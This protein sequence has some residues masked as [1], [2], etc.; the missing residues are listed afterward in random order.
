M[1]ASHTVTQT[2]NYLKQFLSRI[3]FKNM[4]RVFFKC[5]SL[6]SNELLPS[7]ETCDAMIMNLRNIE[8]AILVSN[9][10]LN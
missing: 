6:Q 4:W 3:S 1:D 8:A 9:T 5:S 10:G 2:R 7:D